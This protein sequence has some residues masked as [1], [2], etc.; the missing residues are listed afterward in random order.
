MSYARYSDLPQE[1]RA[2]S[3]EL[4]HNTTVRRFRKVRCN[5]KWVE[6]FKLRPRTE[7][8]IGKPPNI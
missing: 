4:I 8:V 5:E 3:P 2:L 1:T 7:G 6:N